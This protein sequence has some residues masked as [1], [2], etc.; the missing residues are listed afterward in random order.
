[1]Y[2]DNIYRFN[3]IIKNYNQVLDRYP[4]DLEV[5]IFFNSKLSL[6]Q[7]FQNLC[8]SDEYLNK[9]KLKYNDEYFIWPKSQYFTVS[10]KNLRY[11]PIAKNACTSFK[12]VFNLINKEILSEDYKYLKLNE[13]EI[14]RFTDLY[15]TQNLLGDYMPHVNIMNQSLNPLHLIIL[16]DPV[17]RIISSFWDKFCKSFHCS[18]TRSNITNRIIQ[19]INIKRKQNVSHVGITFEQFVDYLCDEDNALLDPHFKPQSKYFNTNGNNKYF[20]IEKT[21]ILLEYLSDEL[22]FNITADRLNS[23]KPINNYKIDDAFKIPID[24]LHQIKIRPSYI[25]FLNKTIEK[26]LLQVYKEDY[27]LLPIQ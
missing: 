15:K 13:N 23:N 5:D 9:N 27:N 16:R 22:G 8:L 6:K 26:K 25:S 3:T 20:F 24:K 7:I 4:T 14:H 10:N 1:M 18:F 11:I 21:N 12:N 19:N 2:F 17:K